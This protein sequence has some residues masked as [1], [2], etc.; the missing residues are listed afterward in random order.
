MWVEP[1]STSCSVGE[2]ATISERFVPAVSAYREAQRQD[3]L[4]HL[5]SPERPVLTWSH[6]DPPSQTEVAQG[7]IQLFTSTEAECQYSFI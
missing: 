4:T 7:E 6:M 1:D 2:E 5:D 3:A